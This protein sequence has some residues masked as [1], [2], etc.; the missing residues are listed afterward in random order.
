MARFSSFGSPFFG[1]RTTDDGII[2]SM[3][4]KEKAREILRK[5][6]AETLERRA[7]RQYNLPTIEF[8]GNIP[9]RTFH[10]LSEADSCFVNGEYN[11]CIA[12]LA[13]AVEYSLGKLLNQASGLE[14]LINL[15]QKWGIANEQDTRVLH[16]LRRY[17]NKVIHSDLA[18][19]AEG[20]VLRKQKAYLTE[21]G[22]IPV[23][24]WEEIK[25]EDE[26]TKDIAA[27]L[28]AEAVVGELVLKVNRVL[29]KLYDG[30]LS[31]NLQS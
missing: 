29:C 16:E 14:T 20:V 15:A 9:S 13:T 27:S 5:L 7:E 2:S 25:P 6:D 8:S 21:K 10:L 3:K 11:G 1:P 28:S 30:K 22:V 24:D 12:V 23:S 19:L 18:G 26:A 31:E 17:R 4:D